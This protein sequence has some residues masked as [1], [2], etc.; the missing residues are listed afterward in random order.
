MVDRQ[1][2]TI[3]EEP[4]WRAWL[5]TTARVGTTNAQMN[6]FI[7]L[8]GFTKPQMLKDMESTD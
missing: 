4:E 3:M 7:N 1:N 2:I 6:N 8:S 5:R